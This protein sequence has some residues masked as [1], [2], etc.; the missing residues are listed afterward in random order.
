MISH[1]ACEEELLTPQGMDKDTFCT[2]GVCGDW[3][4]SSAPASVERACAMEELS[5]V[6]PVAMSCGVRITLALLH[7]PWLIT[8]YLM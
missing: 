5:L 2:G 1:M 6:P 4:L 8:C 3:L 7:M